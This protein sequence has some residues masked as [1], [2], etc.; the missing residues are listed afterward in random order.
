LLDIVA[1]TVR[2]KSLVH[3]SVALQ[4]PSPT[5]I[6][7]ALHHTAAQNLEDIPAACKFPDVFPEDLTGMPPDRDV[8][9][10]IELQPGSVPIS[11]QPYKMTPKELAE[12]KVQ[13]NKL[14]DKGYI[15]PSYSPW[16]CP[17]LFTKKK[18]HSLGLCVDY[19]PLNAVTIK[20]NY[21]LPRIDI[22]FDQLTGARVFSKIDL[23][24]GY[25]QIKIHPKDVHKTDFSIKYELYE[26]LVMLFGLTNA[27]AHFMYLMNSV[28][29]L[30]LDKFV[31]VFIDDILIYS[32]SEEEHAQYLWIILQQLRDHQLYAKLSKCAFWLKEVLFLRHIISTEG[33]AV[34]PSKVQEVLDWKSPRSVTQIRSFL[35]LAG[36][37]R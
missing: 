15:H 5:S 1:R 9:F 16:G 30:E 12:L 17:A 31:M 36:Y 21:L 35:G 37:Y 7:S 34:N 8:D 14:L 13:L 28:F 23:R 27:P 32:K 26:Y 33:I 24:S 6:A 20:N 2:L 10:I 22:L 19:R 3:G 29:M 25:H 11:R 4:L 18:D